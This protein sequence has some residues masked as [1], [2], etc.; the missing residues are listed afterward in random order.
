M[1]I[2]LNSFSSDRSFLYY[3]RNQSS[4]LNY[5]STSF[6]V[7]PENKWNG[8]NHIELASVVVVAVAVAVAF[9]GTIR[10]NS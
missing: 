2:L 1:I 6:G 3:H 5:L 9:V 4:T 10:S 7:H 8:N